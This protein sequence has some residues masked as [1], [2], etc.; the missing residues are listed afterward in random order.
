M[1]T[2]Q[3]LSRR[4]GNCLRNRLGECIDE[5]DPHPAV[6]PTCLRL[7]EDASVAGKL[8]NSQS[9]RRYEIE[10]SRL[11]RLGPSFNSMYVCQASPSRSQLEESASGITGLG[12]PARGLF[13]QCGNPPIIPQV[14]NGNVPTQLSLQVLTIGNGTP[15]H[16]GYKRGR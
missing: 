2:L 4:V 8:Q 13:R 9:E 11:N 14:S 3:A 6:A 7:E 15:P 10:R 16:R 5:V 1:R 12:Q